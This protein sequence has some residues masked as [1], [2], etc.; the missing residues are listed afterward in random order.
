MAILVLVLA[1]IIY[2]QHQV[3]SPSNLDGGSVT[4]SLSNVDVSASGDELKEKSEKK[5]SSGRK[6]HGY[7]VVSELT[8]DD[9]RFVQGL[10]YHDGYLYEGT[11]LY[12]DSNVY[13]INAITGET[14]KQLKVPLPDYLFGEGIAYFNNEI[15]QLTWKDRVGL[16]YN[17]ETMEIIPSKF[18]FEFESH[19]GEG[20][21]ITHDPVRNEFVV[22]DGSE[23][24]HFWDDETMKENRRVRVHFLDDFSRIRYFSKLNELEY[25]NGKILA[26][27]WYQDKIISIDPDT[28]IVEKVYDFTNLFPKK[29]RGV[30]SLGEKVDCFNGISISDVEGEV[31]V[32]GKY[33]PKIYRV[34]LEE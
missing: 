24:L 28:G 11:G 4:E 12:G 30:N 7:T 23:Y 1:V 34:K 26:N 31:F 19:T 22:S 18:L 16:I 2:R 32:T 33:W 17:A 9:T 25:V 13:K 6:M 29:D 15:V 8:H 3:F 27:V 20:W 5:K 10:T 21:G 14:V